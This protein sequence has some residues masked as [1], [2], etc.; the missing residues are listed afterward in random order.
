MPQLQ[1]LKP[2]RK[3]PALQ[4]LSSKKQGLAASCEK[5]KLVTSWTNRVCIEAINLV[6]CVIAFT[7]IRQAPSQDHIRHGEVKFAAL[8]VG[9]VLSYPSDN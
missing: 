7:P 6:S 2:G 5:V 1:S 9:E 3:Q 8:E 4:P